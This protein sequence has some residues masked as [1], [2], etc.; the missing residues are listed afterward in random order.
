QEAADQLMREVIEADIKAERERVRIE[1]T[2]AG[3][4][5][6]GPVARECTFAGFMKCGPM[7][8]HGTEGVV[9][10]CQWFK[11]MENTFEISECAEGRKVKFATAT[12]HGRALTWW[13]SQV[14]TLGREVANG[15]PW[16]DVKHMLID[17]FCP[18]E[19]VQRLEDEL[20]HLKLRDMNI[21]AYTER[22][23]ELALLCPEV[24]PTEK[25]NVELY[26]GET[27]SS[28]PAT[29]NEA[30]RMAHALMEQKIQAK[31]ERIAEGLKRK[32]EINNQG[33]SCNTPKN[34]LQRSGIPN[35]VL[36][37][38]TQQ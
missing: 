18:I 9:G 22:F 23:N 6:R 2:R 16:T 29:L 24:V 14:A 1:A 31:D 25:K 4:P 13:N 11:N 36:L 28:R 33:G 34:H 8:F 37:R 27:T 32:W 7:Q 26:K 12:L 17:E 19:E 38:N 20:R 15:R 35:G 10:L 21:A 30:V 3:G 5:A